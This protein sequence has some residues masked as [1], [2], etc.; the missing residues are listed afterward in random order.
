MSNTS[1]TRRKILTITYLN[2]TRHILLWFFFFFTFIYLHLFFD[3]SLLSTCRHTYSVADKLRQCYVRKR[4]KG[5][6]KEVEV[7]ADLDD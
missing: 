1:H 3:Q 5:Q 2:V 6:E 7:H 4:K